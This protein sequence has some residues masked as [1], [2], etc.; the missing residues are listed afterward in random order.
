M[1]LIIAVLSGYTVL[2]RQK[3]G[4]NVTDDKMNSKK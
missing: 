1:F 2:I 4:R 3:I